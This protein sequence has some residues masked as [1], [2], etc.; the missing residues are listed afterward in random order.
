MIFK[1]QHLNCLPM[2]CRFNIIHHGMFGKYDS[3]TNLLFWVDFL[4][5]IHQKEE[6]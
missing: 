5:I 1:D 6:I 2:W 4:Y 3:P